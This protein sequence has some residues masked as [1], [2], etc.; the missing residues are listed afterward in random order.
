[1]EHTYRATMTLELE[2]QSRRARTAYEVEQLAGE[3]I[4]A[5][6]QAEVLNRSVEIAEP[7]C[8][9]LNR[10]NS[11]DHRTYQCGMFAADAIHG[12]VEACSAERGSPCDRPD[13]HHDFV[14]PG[15]EAPVEP[16]AVAS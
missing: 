11:I 8:A 6:L 3:I 14:S 12:S 13:D 5:G 10:I 9:A 15:W 7:G 2:I 1:M 16:T 4:A